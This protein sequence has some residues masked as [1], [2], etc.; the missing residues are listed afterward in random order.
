MPMPMEWFAFDSARIARIA[1]KPASL[2][3]PH[4]SLHVAT[5][6]T[7]ATRARVVIGAPE[8]CWGSAGK[9]WFSCDTMC[10]VLTGG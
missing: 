4:V 8:A 5:G 6:I 10:V 1:C 2:R 3:V 7:C 9:A